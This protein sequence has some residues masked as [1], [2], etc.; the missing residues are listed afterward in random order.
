MRDIKE[1]IKLRYYFLQVPDLF[2]Q[3]TFYYLKLSKGSQAAQKM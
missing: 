2:S 1:I 3:H